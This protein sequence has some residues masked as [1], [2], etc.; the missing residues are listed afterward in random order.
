MT[1][2]TNP[3]AYSSEGEESAAV[4][5]GLLN[6]AAYQHPSGRNAAVKFCLVFSY[7]FKR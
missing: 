7:W 5:T 6:L 4:P 2:E 1:D 3:F